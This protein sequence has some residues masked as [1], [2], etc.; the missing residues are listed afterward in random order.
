MYNNKLLPILDL[1]IQYLGRGT[2]GIVV[3]AE[4]QIR[5]SQVAV[6]VNHIPEDETGDSRYEEIVLKMI[7]DIP[8][9]RAQ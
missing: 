9:I 6:K 5:R 7:A 1:A 3:R 4:D 8:E 2:G